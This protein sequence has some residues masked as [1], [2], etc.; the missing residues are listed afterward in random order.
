MML[1]FCPAAYSFSV[2][3][4]GLIFIKSLPI[5][6]KHYCDFKLIFNAVYNAFIILLALVW[7]KIANFDFQRDYFFT[8]FFIVVLLA[9]W[10]NIIFGYLYLY[11][12]DI[13]T[14]NFIKTWFFLIA[15]LPLIFNA[16]INAAL[17]VAGGFCSARLSYTFAIYFVSHLAIRYMAF[18][19]L[20]KFS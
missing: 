5:S 11:A 4:S 15:G 12:A 1:F 6:F 17:I 13:K 3:K 18:K 9:L 10:T 2:E 14:G 20:D 8:K 16:S 19:K 7:L